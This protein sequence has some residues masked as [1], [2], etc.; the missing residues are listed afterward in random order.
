MARSARWVEAG[1]VTRWVAQ[2]PARAGGLR[3][4]GPGEPEARQDAGVLEEGDGRDLVAVEGEHDQP[5]GVRDGGVLVTEVEAEGG[6]GVGAG[7]HELEPA[8]SARGGP[9]AEE[10]GYGHRALVLVRHGRHREPRV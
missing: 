5:G 1:L 6:L 4:Q 2:A 3:G 10:G 9:V 7:G 8:G